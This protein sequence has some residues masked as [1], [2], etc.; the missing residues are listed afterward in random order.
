[1]Q[2]G[3]DVR[4]RQCLAGVSPQMNA[5]QRGAQIKTYFDRV[6]FAEFGGPSERA[7]QIACSLSDERFVLH[8]EHQ[9]MNRILEIIFSVRRC[10]RAW[11]RVQR[12]DGSALR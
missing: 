9:N 7:E 12:L 2:R 4:V 10:E 8:E 6:I 5:S 1:V 11:D 3:N